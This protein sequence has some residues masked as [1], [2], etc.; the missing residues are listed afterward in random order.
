MRQ[1]R[2]GS[3]YRDTHFR[4]LD[5][6]SD[7]EAG[8]IGAADAASLAAAF[9]EL[10]EA[11]LKVTESTEEEPAVLDEDEDMEAILE[12]TRSMLANEAQKPPEIAGDMAGNSAAK[13][14]WAL[15]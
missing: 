12:Q 14:R 1:A 9:I 6:S 4:M 13:D 5:G 2:V 10:G 8:E 11:H 3:A 7:D 15:D